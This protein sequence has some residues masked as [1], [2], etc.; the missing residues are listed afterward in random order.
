MQSG[1]PPAR[2]QVFCGGGGGGGGGWGGRVA[3]VFLVCGSHE[4]LLIF[5]HPRCHFSYGPSLSI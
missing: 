2:L 4:F 3:L 1:Y 5:T